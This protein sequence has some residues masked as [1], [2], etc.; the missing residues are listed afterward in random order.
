MA[1]KQMGAQFYP[2]CTQIRVTGDGSTKLP[3]GVALPGVY[4]PDD[5]KGVCVALEEYIR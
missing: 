5:M 2:S 3:E 1:D 4:S